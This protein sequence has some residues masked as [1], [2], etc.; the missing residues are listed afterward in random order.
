VDVGLGLGLTPKHE[1]A[2]HSIVRVF[3]KPMGIIARAS[4]EYVHVPPWIDRFGTLHSPNAKL[5]AQA[6]IQLW[7][8]DQ[9]AR[10]RANVQTLPISGTQ[11]P[12]AAT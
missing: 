10:I 12:K 9:T 11:R 8:A 6:S 5:I 2:S 7:S 1:F 3:Q 4:W